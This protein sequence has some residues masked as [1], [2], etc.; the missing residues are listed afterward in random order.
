MDFRSL[1][2]QRTELPPHPQSA[3]AGWM[4]KDAPTES[5]LPGQ[6][7]AGKKPAR[8]AGKWKD[9]VAFLCCVK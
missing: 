6:L 9:G 4:G 8:L 7:T 5:L 3:S 2:F 1:I